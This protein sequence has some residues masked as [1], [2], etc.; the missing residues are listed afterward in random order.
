MALNLDFSSTP[1]NEP[2]EEGVYEL[3]IIEAEETKSRDKGTPMVKITFEEPQT[4]KRIWENF[5]LTDKA[6]WKIRSLLEVLGFRCDGAVEFEATD[7][8]GSTVRCKVIGDTYNDQPVN[9][10]KRFYA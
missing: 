5:I 4:K 6:L 7:L 3:V 2:L 8:I 10:I 9:R 1:T